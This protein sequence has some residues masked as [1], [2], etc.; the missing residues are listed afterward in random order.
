MQKKKL[1]SW[2]TEIFK[3]SQ[4][5]DP[6]WT[7]SI[8]IAICWYLEDSKRQDVQKVKNRWSKLY[9]YRNSFIIHKGSNRFQIVST[10]HTYIRDFYE[11][12]QAAYGDISQAY[13][14]CETMLERDLYLKAPQEIN[15]DPYMVLKAIKPLYGIKAE[16]GLHWYM[17]Y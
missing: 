9:G 1:V 15:F 17:A 6:R 2:L 10:S 4:Q 3:R 7:K 14:Q 12:I 11:G 5:Q 16:S 13:T 8:S